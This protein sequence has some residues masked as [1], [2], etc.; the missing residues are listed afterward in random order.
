M[1]EL[2]FL[3]GLAILFASLPVKADPDNACQGTCV[4]PEDMKS[5]VASAKLKSCMNHTQPTIESDSITIVTDKDGRVFFSGA[6]PHPYTLRMK[7]CEYELEAKSTIHVVAAMQPAPTSGFRLRPKAYLGYALAE[8]LRTN[9][10]ARDGLDA[11]LAEEILYWR[12]LN[13]N[14]AVG[15]RTFGAGLGIDIFRSFGAYAGY[16][17]TWDGFR[18]NPLVSLWFAFW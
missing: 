9:G 15:V 8:P 18:A 1:T 5:L 2:R 14:V 16:A 12:N 7:W 17:M 11:G 4:P 10:Q 13:L 6:A 3:A